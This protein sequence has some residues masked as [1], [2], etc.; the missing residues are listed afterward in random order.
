MKFFISLFSKSILIFVLAY[1]NLSAQW[2]TNPAINNIVCNAGGDQ[3]NPKLISDGIGGAI[4]TWRDF[5][6]GNFDIYAQKVNA[7]GVVQWTPNGVPLCTAVNDQFAPAIVSDG[8]GGAIVTW[9]DSRDGANFKL[10][11]QKINASGAVQWTT[12]GVILCT[13]ATNQS[14]PAIASDDSGGAIVTWYENRNGTDND[15]YAQRINVSGV[16]QWIPTGVALCTAIFNQSYPKIISDGFRGAI[17]TWEDVRNG[18]SDIY[19]QRI[20]ASGVVQWPVDGVDL[21][22]A[23][24]V[25]QLPVIVSDGVGGAIVT[26]ADYRSGTNYDVYAQKVNALGYIQWPSQGVALCIAANNQQNPTIHDDGSGGAFVAWQDLRSGVLNIYAQ[27]ISTSGTVQWNS[28]GVA[29]SPSVSAQSVPTI[30][31]DMLGGIIVSWQAYNGT[32]YDVYAQKIDVSGKVQ[33]TAN[34]VAISTAVDYQQFPAMIGDGSGGGIVVWQDLRNTN[35]LDIYVQKFDEHG[36]L[37]QTEPKLSAVKDVANDQGGKMRVLWTHSLLDVPSKNIIHSY[38]IKMGVKNTKIMGKTTS[39]G[40]AVA[41]FIFWETIGS[42]QADW[43]TGYSMVVP[44][45]ADS[46]LQGIPMYYFQVL[47][48]SDSNVFWKSNI[49]SGYSVDNIPP[50]GVPVAAISGGQNSRVLLQWNKNRV[51]P[52]VMGYYV[53]RSATPGFSPNGTTILALATDTSFVDTAKL[54]N[55]KYYYRVATVDMHGNAGIASSELQVLV[56][57]VGDANDVMPK[58]FALLQN[59]PNPF[60]PSTTISYQLPVNGHISLKV[61][62]AIG[63]EVATLVNEVKDAG[64]YSAQFDGS[65]LASGIYFTRLQSGDKV[66]LKK[67]MLVK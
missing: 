7:S 33:W 59:Y 2:S 62:D 27:Q 10:Y 56:T 1:S 12:D 41:D 9:S 47:A 65:K 3:S 20:N 22:T 6:N 16:V 61:Y 8:L 48:N 25:Q 64:S 4:I 11:T 23:A 37:G 32:N 44:T 28:D 46:G 26:W 24:N 38:T 36:I 42:R 52:D 67:M 45:Y 40:P 17:V 60:N 19:A 14:A 21:C 30:I 29:L 18:N 43:S 5:R 15:I 57:E 58:T 66:Q 55:Q 49:D 54:N 51:D 63:R 53:Y 31:N 34:G 50:V 35:D 39:T 13:A